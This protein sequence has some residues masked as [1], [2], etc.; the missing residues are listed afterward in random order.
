M[1]IHD[2]ENYIWMKPEENVNIK[3]PCLIANAVVRSAS[4]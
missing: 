2:P 3:V 4:S 1:D